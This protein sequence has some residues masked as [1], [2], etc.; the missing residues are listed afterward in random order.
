MRQF[1]L[2]Q[3]ERIYKANMHTHTTL[4]DGDL[5][6]EEMK[7][8]Y[9]SHGYQIIA[10]SDHD[11][12]FPQSALN[13]HDFLTLTSYEVAINEHNP[14]S[15]YDKCYHLNLFARDP[16]NVRLVCFDPVYGKSTLEERPGLENSLVIHNREDRIYSTEYVNH[17]IDEANKAGFFVSYN[18]PRWSQQNYA[19]YIGLRGIWGI[20]VYNSDCAQGGFG[21]EDVRPFEDLLRAGVPVFPLATDDIH[22]PRDAFGGFLMVAAKTLSYGDVITA[23]ENGDFYASTGA[24]IRELSLE[25]GKLNVVC[26]PAHHICVETECRCAF[27]ANAPAGGTLTEATI[28]LSK[29]YNI[30]REGN[31]IPAYFRVSVVDTNGKRAWSR[32][33][34]LS[35]VSKSFEQG[36]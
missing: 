17:L 23:L 9:K 35:E 29:W 11:F 10:Y 13:D 33:Y 7:A 1:L 22:A 19:D 25:N 16:E 30:S 3:T 21:E 14:R 20:E 18:H 15:P 2:P 24:Q 28:N 12:C 31:Q 34:Y 32:P 6:P 26:D 36:D 8:L 27:R 5:T 4:S